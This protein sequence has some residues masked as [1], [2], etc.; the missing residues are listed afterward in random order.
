MLAYWSISDCISYE[1]V[2]GLK[3]AKL[4]VE[5]VSA[6]QRALTDKEKVF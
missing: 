1:D 6:S 3:L 5:T 2:A 4:L